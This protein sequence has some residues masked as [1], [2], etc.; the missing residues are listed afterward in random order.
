MD[1]IEKDSETYERV[2]AV[3]QPSTLHRVEVVT[4]MVEAMTT[5]MLLLSTKE[6]EQSCKANERFY[7]CY[8]N[9]HSSA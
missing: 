2:V 8:S 1:C 7:S 4:A 6:V 3:R 9:E 5:T